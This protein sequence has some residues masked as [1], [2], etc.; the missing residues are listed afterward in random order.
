MGPCGAIEVAHDITEIVYP[1]LHKRSGSIR[2]INESKAAVEIS[3]IASIVTRCVR[4][5]PNDYARIVYVI[6]RRGLCPRYVN[7]GERP[8]AKQETVIGSASIRVYPNNL[9][10]VVDTVRVAGRCA[11]RLDRGEASTA[12]QKAVLDSPAIPE[13]THCLS[14]G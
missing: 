12:Q 4:E 7:R 11:H 8:T 14:E 6:G 1:S 10:T 3:L 13:K 5:E 9:A 2:R